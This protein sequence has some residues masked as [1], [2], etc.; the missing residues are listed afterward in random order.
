MIT[1]LRHPL[2]G[3]TCTIHEHGA[4][5]LS[6]VNAKGRDLLFVSN[7]A[8]LDG[9]K[10][11]RGGIPL[12]FPIFGPPPN[13]AGSN[14]GTEKQSTMPQHGFARNNKWTLVG[15]PTIDVSVGTVGATFRLDLKD[16]SNGRGT[17]NPW[18]TD[19]LYDVRLELT[20]E[21]HENGALTTELAVHNTGRA[22]FEFQALFHT[23]YRVS[24]GAALDPKLT[25]VHGLGGYSALDQLTLQT[26]VMGADESVTIGSEVDRIHTP[27]SDS[28]SAANVTIGVGGDADGTDVVEM[29]CEATIRTAGRHGDSA[30]TTS[31]SVPVSV[32]VWNPH[33]DKAAA[34]GDFGN[35]EY[36]D[37]ICVEPGI[38]QRRVFLEPGQVATLRQSMLHKRVD[39]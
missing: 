28:T 9:S 32:V 36:V 6:Y 14:E 17:D 12:V 1:E 19:A 2:T 5:V 33:V 34:M 10:A 26:K 7:K 25:Y 16:V 3:A 4:T 31:T 13:K 37:M 20:V 15:R 30:A 39:A 23:Y 35:D 18:A 24:G 21:I 29:K 8:V 11:I 27:P 22:A 38:L